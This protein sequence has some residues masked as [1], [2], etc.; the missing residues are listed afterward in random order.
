MAL[1]GCVSN[2]LDALSNGCS[3]TLTGVNCAPPPTTSTSSSTGPVTTTTT[4]TT[5]TTAP[6]VNTGNTATLTTGDT[7]IA[8][9]G[10]ITVTTLTTPA[11]SKL[12]DS[13]LNHVS[14]NQT[15]AQQ[16]WFDTKTP[17]NV[18]WPVS[19]PMVYFAG[20]TNP[21]ANMG[22]D[23]K[24]YRYYLKGVY[25]EELQVWTWAN[26]Y[27]TQYRDVTASGTD[28]QHQA[29]SFGGNYT[30]TT[31]IVP[32]LGQVDYTG[33]WGATAKTS[34]FVDTSDLN[35]TVSYN[36]NWRVN[37]TSSLHADFGSNSFWGTLSPTLW[38]GVNKNNGLTYVDPIA[39]QSNSA[40][41][42]AQAA[43][44]DPTTAAGLP[45]YTN[46]INYN[47]AF[48]KTNVVLKG[49][50]STSTTNKTKPNQIAGTASEDP[51]DGWITSANNPMFAGIFGPT[52]KE[53]TGVFALDAALPGPND[54]RQPINNDRIGFIQMSGIFNGTAP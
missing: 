8:L 18:N 25:N 30:P 46:W 45:V 34:N 29:F 51:A 36:N 10:S 32:T 19:K 13:P 39:A 27:A 54:G 1:T 14:V 28:P 17:S 5:T 7:T 20:S 41:C 21:A 12:V 38:Q 33:Q 52:A 22:A 35:Q 3:T 42:L 48:M 6:T 24:L 23:Y 53:I 26:S 9:E 43:S 49:A 44:C 40:A 2:T 11:L 50:L 4:G 31:A 16:I 37:G 15:A 47:Q